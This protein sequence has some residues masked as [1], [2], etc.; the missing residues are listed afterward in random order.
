MIVDVHVEKAGYLYSSRMIHPQRRDRLLGVFVE[1][2]ACGTGLGAAGLLRVG[3]LCQCG[4]RVVNL[5]AIADDNPRVVMAN[6]AD[7]PQTWSTRIP[8]IVPSD[9]GL[10]GAIPLPP[11]EWHPAFTEEGWAAQNRKINDLL[12]GR[13]G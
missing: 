13:A 3:Y 7:R 8:T 5:L 12:M 1:C 10:D 2:G 4:A 9:T 11:D 6:A